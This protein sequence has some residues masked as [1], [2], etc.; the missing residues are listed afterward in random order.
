MSWPVTTYIA[1]RLP[2]ADRLQQNEDYVMAY[3]EI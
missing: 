3:S 1:L 2:N